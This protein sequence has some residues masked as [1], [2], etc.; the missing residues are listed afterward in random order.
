MTATVPEIV[1]PDA[2][3][4]IAIVGADVLLTVT[5]TAALVVDCPA[6]LEATAKSECVPFERPAVFRDRLNGAAVTAAPEFAPSTLN[7]TLVVLVETAVAIAAVPEIVA[8]EAGEVMEMVGAEVL[9]TVTATAA[10]VAVCPAALEATAESECVPFE[11]AV[12]FSERLNGAAAS[13]APEL[14]PSILNCTF[15]V[16]AETLVRIV[17]V[18]ET[19][20][21]EPGDV[22]EIEGAEVLLTMTETLALVADCP[23]AF[24]ATAESECVPLVGLAVFR[25]RLNGAA[26][27]A[28]PEFAP[29]TLNCTLFVLEETLVKMA[30]VPEIVS[31]PVGEVMETDGA[32]ELLTVTFTA[33]LVAD[34][35]ATS[36]ATAVSVWLPLERVAVLSAR[37]NGVLVS[38]APSSVPST[39]N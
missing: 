38:A 21:P 5:V 17:V 13:T 12:V 22:I 14:V 25:D 32:E 1:A 19:V 15:V 29:S 37:V 39:L 6:A 16:L 24:V 7:C 27:V 9:F 11:S 36:L 18:P 33:A 31:P 30:T 4:V 10:L 20:A 28:G 23:A 35:P 2:G 3:E 34:W 26:V 8:P